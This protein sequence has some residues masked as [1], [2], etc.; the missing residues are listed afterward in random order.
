MWPQMVDTL[1][2]P[3]AFKVAAEQHNCLSLNKGGQTPISILHGV[4][5]ETV[6]VKSFH[7]LICPVYVLDSRAQSTS[8]PSPPKWESRSR[9]GIYLGHSP[10]HAGNV[11]LVFNPHTGRVSPQYPVVFNDIFLTVPFMDAGMVPPHWADLH[12]Y[13]TKRTTNKEF[14]LAEEWMKEMPD[15]VDVSAA[16]DRLTDPFALI[17]DQNQAQT[18]DSETPVAL[19]CDTSSSQVMIPFPRE[20]T[21]EP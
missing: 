9:I 15:H 1:F 13:S 14:N 3:F 20:S 12:K 10:F 6:P 17:P 18:L 8:N 19:V 11:A 16:G 2:W 7:T 5:S 4:P 21:N